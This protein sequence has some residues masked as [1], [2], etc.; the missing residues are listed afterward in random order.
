M[1]PW[2]GEACVYTAWPDSGATFRG[3]QGPNGITASTRSIS[4]PAQ[5]AGF[6]RAVFD[7][8]PGIVSRGPNGEI[9]FNPPSIPI[10]GI[11]FEWTWDHVNIAG[12]WFSIPDF[13]I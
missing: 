8:A 4:P 1:C 5:Q 10:P 13:R 11:H 2:F 9:G 7:P 3:W 12:H 6:V